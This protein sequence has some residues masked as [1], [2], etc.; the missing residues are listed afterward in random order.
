MK[1]TGG[2]LLGWLAAGALSVCAVLVGG[3]CASQ[4]AAVQKA[5][6][7][8][9][10]GGAVDATL[11]DSDAREG[12]KDAVWGF[13]ERGR[14]R[15]LTGN[16]EGSCSDYEAAARAYEALDA[17]AVV[18]M[19][20]AASQ[21]AALLANDQVLPYAGETYERV[22]L[23][24][25]DAFNR[26]ALGRTE[27]I[28]VDVR[29]AADLLE[30]ALDE[31]GKKGDEF[32]EADAQTRAQTEKTMETAEYRA[33]SAAADAV[34]GSAAN[35]FQS[36][37]TYALAG[38]WY[39]SKQMWGDAAIAFGRAYTL[40]PQNRAF[41]DGMKQAAVKMGKKVNGY[42]PAAAGEGWVTVFLEQGYNAEKQSFTLP[43]L[44]PHNYVQASIPFY[45]CSHDPEPMVPASVW[46]DGRKLA[47]TQEGCDYRVLAVKAL[48]ERMPAILA[49]QIARSI[50]K[51]VINEQVRQKD[52][53]GLAAFAVMVG[54][55][56]SEQADLRSW[57]LMPRHGQVGRFRLA[58]GEYE[59]EVVMGAGRA[60]VR[61]A[62]QAGRP[63]I[64]HVVAVPGVLRIEV[65]P[66]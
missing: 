18:S 19:S 36:A 4:T 46:L 47:E 33:M 59:L 28:G 21:G 32:R 63:T 24:T 48:K 23:F 22:M 9:A 60:K 6:A 12:D 45:D 57:R 50:A 51:A 16:L 2:N 56:L 65:T 61:T 53:T 43:L 42:E 54:N 30:A 44:L 35:S 20:G 58:A 26:A 31:H 17:R 3:G 49:R 14:L 38:T 13:M 29:N 5:K 52:S 8:L 55:A 10:A 15:Q 39:E 25:L 40:Q 7:Q 62:V 37:Y 27:E 66:L 1:T 11:F 64:L 34:A 41:A